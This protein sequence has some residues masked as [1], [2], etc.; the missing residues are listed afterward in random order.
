MLTFLEAEF[1]SGDVT[2]LAAPPGPQMP[3]DAFYF[4]IEDDTGLLGTVG[5]T[6]DF[7]SSQ[8]PTALVE[9]LHV[10]DLPARVRRAGAGCCVLLATGK[11]PTAVPL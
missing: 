7:L 11:P 10:D 6:P 3:A 2:R 1:A 9:R 4:R 5:A 8:S